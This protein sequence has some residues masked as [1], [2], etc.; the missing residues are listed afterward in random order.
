MQLIERKEARAFNGET[1]LAFDLDTK[2]LNDQGEFEGYASTFGNVDR[3]GDICVQGCFTESL[4]KRP[5]GKVKM[6]YQHDTSRLCGVWTEMSEDSRGLYVKG[7]LLLTTQDGKETYE[8]MRAGAL[9]AMSIG[10]RTLLDE[11]DR[12][13]GVRKIMKADLLEVSLVTFPMNERA[14]VSAVK[15]TVAFSTQDWRDIEAALRDEGL[16]RAD[17]VKA[18]SGFKTWLHRDGGGPEQGLRDGAASANDDT[19]TLL[20]LRRLAAALRG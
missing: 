3:G 18:V 13:T 11:I 16:S 8:L 10:Y 19:H 12:T 7:R 6:L 20:A 17:A 1:G 9:D 15:S 14:T 5:A 2:A 4:Q